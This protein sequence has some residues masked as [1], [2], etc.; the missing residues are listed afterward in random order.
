MNGWRERWFTRRN[1]LRFVVVLFAGLIVGL[2]S[3]TPGPGNDD[4]RTLEVHELTVAPCDPTQRACHAIGDDLSLD[5]HL[6]GRVSALKSFPVL[7]RLRS[8]TTDATAVTIAFTMPGM[9][10]G[11]NRYRLQR[12]ADGR[13]IGNVLLPVCATGRKDWLADVEVMAGTRGY[14][15]RFRFTVE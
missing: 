2:L 12:Q 14:H 13:W 10:M 6:Q 4:A 3:H 11:V 8:R 7:V 1:L 15:A 9:D 5:L